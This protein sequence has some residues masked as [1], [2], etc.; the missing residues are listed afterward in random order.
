VVRRFRERIKFMAKGRKKY[1]LDE[2]HYIMGLRIF[3]F[4]G[5]FILVFNLKIFGE[6]KNKVIFVYPTPS[7]LKYA[8]SQPLLFQ[9]R[10]EDDYEVLAYIEPK[11]IQR[12]SIIKKIKL[13][14]CL[15]KKTD[16]LRVFSDDHELTITASQKTEFFLP[17]KLPQQG[18]SIENYPY[19]KV[20]LKQFYMDKP[21][22]IE[23]DFG[24]DTDKDDK[25][26]TTAVVPVRLFLANPIETI[27]FKD[28]IFIPKSYFY[29][30]KRKLGLSF[31]EKWRYAQDGPNVVIQ[32][33]F[34]KDISQ[35]STIEL[36]CSS[37][38][39]ILRV[40]FLIDFNRNNK[41]D[42]ILEYEQTMHQAFTKGGYQYVRINLLKT[43][44][45]RFSKKDKA[46]LSE[47]IIF[48]QGQKEKII[49][50]MP[51]VRLSFYPPSGDK[52][53]KDSKTVFLRPQIRQNKIIVDF[54]KLAENDIYSGKIKSASFHFKFSEKSGVILKGAQCYD[55]IEEDFPVCLTLGK[56]ILNNLGIP[57]DI[58]KQDVIVKPTI[59]EGGFFNTKWSFYSDSSNYRENPKWE[60]KTHGKGIKLHYK[61]EQP[62]G[63]S[64]KKNVCFSIDKDTYIISHF[65]LPSF[66]KLS[67][68]LY[69]RDGKK[70]SLPIYNGV[71]IKFSEIK[72]THIIKQV[73]LKASY[74]PLSEEIDTFEREF[75]CFL[76]DIFFFKIST[77][78]F[79]TLNSSLSNQKPQ[80]TNQYA[81]LYGLKFPDFS[82][83]PLKITS[84]KATDGI[85]VWTKENQTRI[86]WLKPAQNGLNVTLEVLP[87]IPILRPTTLSFHYNLP[88]RLARANPY[89]LVL[90]IETDKGTVLKKLH[91]DS[92]SGQK[93]ISL[94]GNELKRIRFKVHFN[95]IPTNQI[96]Q[97]I[98]SNIR[99][100]SFTPQTLPHI[101]THWL[102]G[103]IEQKTLKMI[104][105]TKEQFTQFLE[106]G[107]WV[108]LDKVYLTSAEHE[109]RLFNHPYLQVK[110]VV[111]KGHKELSEIPL[112][113]KTQKTGL[114]LLSILL[115]LI[116][117]LPLLAV[118]YFLFKT[119]RV[120]RVLTNLKKLFSPWQKV[121]WWVKL[122]L[123]MA[124]SIWLYWS[125]L[126]RKVGQGG[127]NQFFTWSSI[128]AAFAYHYISFALR[129]F[130]E[131]KYKKFAGFIYGGAGS[132]YIFGFMVFLTI[133]A[134]FL[135][136]NLEPIANQA[137]IIG[138]YLLVVGV[139]KELIAFKKASFQGQEIEQK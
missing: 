26:D 42:A 120:H 58:F 125:G 66:F 119:R 4:F 84:S 112:S 115:K 38:Q 104:L 85:Q 95:S 129:P 99:V 10:L 76:K 60:I 75:T 121:P 118:A 109:L 126:R 12:E 92:Q 73:R 69:A 111:F 33:R 64:L 101:F 106:G 37:K 8:E 16:G 46:W 63:F 28:A 68:E 137:A 74:Q 22:G 70:F 50:E 15:P 97:L 102:L 1:S 124:L 80:P 6:D 45:K 122:P 138:Y 25:I 56:Q 71:P 83:I 114:H 7:G 52:E 113:T 34:A 41:P 100:K 86:F 108:K 21:L 135:I 139:V 20:S 132:I 2:K 98:L 134:M 72:K 62:P 133:A 89:W 13:P 90:E 18:V 17:L 130:F 87:S 78:P 91:L 88:S 9:P 79:S 43:I 3:L 32:R 53:R 14:F 94:D 65:Q 54:S 103:Q 24:I 30:L 67:L 55:A 110:T 116:I 19:F 59:L 136:V 35:Y 49:K 47:V 51:L 105:L 61:G 48:I 5:L 123:F 23:M 36:V 39:P 81:A 117:L 44:Q 77:I 93:E 82:G 127:E 128:C 40:N 11:T 131:K 107:V 96:Y 57:G 27:N 29:L 31:D